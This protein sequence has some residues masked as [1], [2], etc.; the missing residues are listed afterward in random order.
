MTN[1]VINQNSSQ[2]LHVDGTNNN[3]FINSDVTLEVAGVGILAEADD[4]GNDII[5]YGDVVSNGLHDA[6]SIA[7][8]FDF[9]HVATGGR[10]ISKQGAGVAFGTGEGNTLLNEG[11]IAGKKFG[12]LGSA[13]EIEIENTGTIRSAGIA[14][15]TG[16]ELETGLI[17][18]NTGTIKSM[19]AVAIMGGSGDEVI[20]NDG[21]IV[22]NVKLGGASDEFF[23]S[24][25]RVEGKVFGGKG[26][27]QFTL[28]KFHANIVETLN[29]GN[30]LV[31]TA[32]TYTLGNNIERLA[33]LGDKDIDASGNGLHNTL[34]GNDGDNILRGHGGSDMLVGSLGNDDLFGGAG[35]DQFVMETGGGRDR[36]MDFDVG[37]LDH[38][39]VDVS[40]FYSGMGGSFFEVQSHMSQHG[41]DVWIDY[42][43]GERMILR[44][45]D[46]DDLDDSHFAFSPL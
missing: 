41:N 28:G 7:G 39:V 5:L 30:D 23:F 29:G 18:E 45:V 13:A 35:G 38:D 46:L 43:A 14:I 44:N 17:L 27:D 33:L 24:N 21:L 36:V 9:V 25:G 34:N 40:D 11:V 8:D 12:F 20:H 2:T 26:D 42:D 3:W 10:A 4:D 19:S 16:S 32:K 1:Y 15:K 22:G 6:I 31:L 37:G